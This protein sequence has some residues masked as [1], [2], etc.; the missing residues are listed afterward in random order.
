MR[1]LAQDFAMTQRYTVPELLQLRESPLVKRPDGLP[2]VETW[3]GPPVDPSQ[4]RTAQPRNKADDNSQH[5]FDKRPSLFDTHVTRRSATVSENIV[6]GPPKLAFASSSSAR[7]PGKT[8][9][10]GLGDLR[11][12]ENATPATRV[13]GKDQDYDDRDHERRGGRTGG[14]HGRRNFKEDKEDWSNRSRRTFDGE[15]NERRPR[16]RWENRRDQADGEESRRDNR[17]EGRWGHRQGQGRG[18][19]DQPWFRSETGSEGLEDSSKS[20]GRQKGWGRDHRSGAGADTEWNARPEQDPEWM[21]S[22]EP[23]SQKQAHTAEDFQKWKE[24]MRAEN[25]KRA[26]VDEIQESVEVMELEAKQQSTKSMSLKVKPETDKFFEL[27]A[28]K[29]APEETAAAVEAKKHKTRFAA[30]FSPP[31]EAPKAAP[32]AHIPEPVRPASTDADQEGFQRI[33][34]MLGGKANRSSSGLPMEALFGAKGPASRSEQASPNPLAGLFSA[35]D[36]NSKAE[37]KQSEPQ[38]QSRNSGGGL[39]SLLGPMS[40]RAT[41]EKKN[42]SD[43]LLRLMQQSKVSPSPQPMP[44]QLPQSNQT[45]GLLQMPEA[46]SRA[47]QPMKTPNE[48]SAFFNEPTGNDAPRPGPPGMDERQRFAP[49]PPPIS[50]DFHYPPRSEYIKSPQDFGPNQLPPMQR[51]PGL[52]T[53]AGWP[54]Q[55]HQL[56][57]QLGPHQGPPGL[58]NS[59]PRG[60]PFPSGPPMPQ[61]MN[62]PIPQSGGPPGPPQERQRKY[63]SGNVP[64]LPPGMPPPPGFMGSN[65]PPPGFSPMPI[66]GNDGM[67]GM[68]QPGGAT[69]PSVGGGGSSSQHGMQPRTLMDLFATAGDRGRGPVGPTGPFR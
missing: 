6:L 59:G 43:F 31:P 66:S 4:R 45:P 55:H 40:P 62:I 3:M 16:Q 2:P 49:R 19:F 26:P 8:N 60:L 41:S 30:L 39:E 48:L 11:T 33:L 28:D 42:E 5:D 35:G 23:E 56:P 15:D 32:E 46:L 36:A 47:R 34:Q 67:I 57:P 14:V 13:F 61:H 10:S 1:S 25:E 65:V 51:P 54:Y 22:P 20:Y 64:F 63:T 69:G 12:A 29:K 58:S 50:S 24:R 7:T 21:D 37:L 68:N 27:Y 38:P 44:S 52:D 17:E 18:K 53:P 9:P